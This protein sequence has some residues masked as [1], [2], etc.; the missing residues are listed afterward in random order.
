MKFV[1]DRCQTRYSI[2]DEKVRQR[3]LRIR[4]KTCGNVI[5]VQSGEVVPG[6]Q[7][8]SRRLEPGGG[9]GSAP[10]P[11]SSSRLARRPS[12]LHEWYVSV[13]GAEQGPLSCRDAAKYI[14]SL[15]PERSVHVWK[16]GM[17]GWKLPK[18]VA[19]IAQEV[20][21]LRRSSSDSAARLRVP[22]S[23]PKSLPAGGSD[24]GAKLSQPGI[25]DSGAKE[26]PPIPGS[27]PKSA[28][29]PISGSGPKSAPPRISGSGPKLAPPPI[30][31]SGPKLAPPAPG[32]GARLAS[33]P[34]PVRVSGSEPLHGGLSPK[35]GPSLPGLTPPSPG[36][37]SSSTTP[38]LDTEFDKAPAT[39]RE[40][41]LSG[42]EGVAEFATP[43]PNTE[44]PTMPHERAAED[45]F[46]QT[47]ITPPP[48]QPLPPVAAPA[49]DGNGGKSWVPPSLPLSAPSATPLY[50]T[51]PPAPLHL[52]Q[53]EAAPSGLAR[54]A[55]LFQRHGHLKYVVAAMFVVNLVIL[56]IVL[57]WR[58]EGAK[59]VPSVHESAARAPEVPSVEPVEETPPRDDTTIEPEARH[60]GRTA[61]VTPR[62]RAAVRPAVRSGKAAVVGEDPFEGPSPSSHRAERPIVPV[63]A[64]QSRRSRS[65]PAGA[66]VKAVSQSQIAEV[67]RNKEHQNGLKTC[68]ERAAKRDGRLRTGRLDI[69]VSVGASGTVQRVQVHGPADFLIIDDCIKDAIRHWRF[70]ASTEEYGTSF[71]LIL[72][73]DGP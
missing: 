18:D 29:P 31:G 6:P 23:G 9:A 11:R 47:Q 49:D 43:L 10:V 24:A 28:P 70:P 1:C 20:S 22:G 66:E 68:Y 59:P 48:V 36:P 60:R 71:P 27:G 38:V 17:D 51:L 32:P 14:V 42:V 19:I 3:I 35:R 55:A 2:A 26:S 39:A 46:D 33:G 52:P 54:L 61:R 57:S 72:Q 25:P 8:S 58:G 5:T 30:P 41:R 37:P 12:G 56:V 4:C 15:P 67:V 44:R 73:G 53:A 50:G 45:E 63:E 16:E 62:R 7:D 21:S 69:T 40:R 13:D 64:D 65:G 34:E